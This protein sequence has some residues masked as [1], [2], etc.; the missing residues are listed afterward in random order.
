MLIADNPLII[1]MRHSRVAE[2]D[3]RVDEVRPVDRPAPPPGLGVEVPRADRRDAHR[4]GLWHQMPGASAQHDGVS[5]NPGINDLG[6][7][8]L[9]LQ[10][11]PLVRATILSKKSCSYKR[12][13]LPSRL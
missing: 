3:S 2:V 4:E 7:A 6:G 11:I 5:E 8:G 9:L 12:N 13:S 10:Y 1:S